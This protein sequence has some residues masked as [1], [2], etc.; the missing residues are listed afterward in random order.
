[1]LWGAGGVAWVANAAL[2]LDAAD[3]TGG[4]YV[5]ESV[6][7]GVHALVL[8]GLVGLDRL[9]VAGDSRWGKVGLRLAIG[10]RILFLT[11][12][13]VAIAVGNDDIPLFPVAAVT[14]AVGMLAAG[15]AI[16]GARRLWGWRRYLP[17]TVGAYPFIFMFPVL[18]VTG[19]RPD[20]ALT[21]WGLTFIGVA[22]ALWTAATQGPG[23]SQ[24][25]DTQG[26]PRERSSAPPSA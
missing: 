9:G 18:A 25:L 21:G 7:L 5:T 12:E 16:I 26:R 17:V 4:F 20:L 14:T 6:W 11:A 8:G 1:M 19:E 10:G 2:G 3:G 22:V 24:R 13:G 23:R 15:S